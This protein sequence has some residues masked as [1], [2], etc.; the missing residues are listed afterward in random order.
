MILAPPLY[1]ILFAYLAF[2][3]I[4]LVFSLIHVYHVFLSASFTFISF[5]A[6]FVVFVLTLFTLYGTAYYLQDVDWQ[7]PIFEVSIGKR[8]PGTLPT[9]TP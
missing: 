8:P 5:I 1:I 9:F 7:Q 4:F 3:G 6:S 2:L